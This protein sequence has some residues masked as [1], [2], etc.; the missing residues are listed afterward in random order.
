MLTIIIHYTLYCDI[1]IHVQFITVYYINYITRAMLCSTAES[2]NIMYFCTYVL[3]LYAI[4][5]KI[6]YL[7]V[8]YEE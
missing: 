1:Q 5:K 6:M 4:K 3:S 7:Y 8:N 2:T